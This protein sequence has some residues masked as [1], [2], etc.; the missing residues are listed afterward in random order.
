MQKVMA[1]KRALSWTRR[2]LSTE[3]ASIQRMWAAIKVRDTQD[4][5]KIEYGL[6][7]DTKLKPLD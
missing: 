1:V 5:T 2:L 4:S 6:S 7:N 3:A